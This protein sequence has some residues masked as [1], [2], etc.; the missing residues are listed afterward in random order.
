[1]IQKNI[2][3]YMKW[4]RNN[5]YMGKY[6]QFWKILKYLSKID[7]LNEN[8]IMC[9]RDNNVCVSKMYGNNIVNARRG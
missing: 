1:M 8:N 7:S 5:N 4:T 6:I 3:L 2:D 9:C